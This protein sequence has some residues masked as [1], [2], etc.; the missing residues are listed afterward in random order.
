VGLEL[1]GRR[2]GIVGL[3]RSG[4]HLARIVRGLGMEV[5]AVRRASSGDELLDVLG[6]ADFVSLHCPLTQATR[7]LFDEARL[8][9]MRRGSFL[10]NTARAPIVDRPALEA[11]LDRGHL[12]GYGADVHWEEPPDPE[13]PL[14]ERPNVVALP[15]VAGATRQSLDRIVEVVVDNIGR[16]E[17]GNEPRYRVA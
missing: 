4:S 15:H 13:D 3:G 11:A 7:G 5:L 8:S 12:A 2:L 10:I 14:L 1:L 6:R 9:A 17:R 16:I